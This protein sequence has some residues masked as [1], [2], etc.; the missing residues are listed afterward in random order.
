MQSLTNVTEEEAFGYVDRVSVKVDA[1]A[2]ALQ[3]Y[4]DLYLNGMEAWTEL[5]RT[6]YPEQLVRP[7]ETIGTVNGKE[8]TFQPLTESKGDIIR[9]IKYPD[10]ESTLNYDYWK[11]AV[12]RLKDKTNNIYS[13]MYWDVRTSTYDHPVNL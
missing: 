12:D 7:G 6:G 11:E 3:K 4:I 13:P 8:Y 10:T 5:R 2:V 9:R 1:E